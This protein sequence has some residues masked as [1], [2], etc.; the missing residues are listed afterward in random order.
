VSIHPSK[1]G[2]TRLKLEKDHKKILELKTK[3]RQAGKEKGKNKEET[4]EKMQEWGH[5]IHSFH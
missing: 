4:M 3:S 2:I 1:V 5:C